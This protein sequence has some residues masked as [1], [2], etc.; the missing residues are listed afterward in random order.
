MYLLLLHI[1]VYSVKCA[2]HKRKKNYW[3][4]YILPALSVLQLYICLTDYYIHYYMYYTL[5][6]IYHLDFYCSTFQL[7][8]VVLG[9]SLF[10]IERSYWIAYRDSKTHLQSVSAIEGGW[11]W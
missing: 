6:C 1:R 3:I 4:S 5:I 11:F 8:V 9:Y 2:M 10:E 7:V